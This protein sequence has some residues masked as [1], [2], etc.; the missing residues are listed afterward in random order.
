MADRFEEV[1]R[2]RVA[3]LED[4][5]TAE[6]DSV[7]EHCAELQSFITFS[8]TRQS[9]E[10]KAEL[11]RELTDQITGLRSELTLDISRL[12]QRLSRLEEKVDAQH[13]TVTLIL[14]QILGRLPA[15]PA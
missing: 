3:A 1:I 10:L 4:R 9:A 12:E 6:A 5:V 8:L 15:G 7:K 11:K 13:E 2:L 14:K